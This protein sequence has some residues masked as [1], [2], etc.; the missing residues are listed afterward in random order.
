MKEHFSLR[1][2]RPKWNIKELN[3]ITKEFKRKIINENLSEDFTRIFR[4][5]FRPLKLSLLLFL[6]NVNT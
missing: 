3:H 4:H 2:T 5:F 6:T 1:F